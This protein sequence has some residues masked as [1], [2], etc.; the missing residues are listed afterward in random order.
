MS[1]TEKN[2]KKQK[3]RNNEYYNLQQTFDDLYEQSRKDK[4]FRGLMQII[5]QKENILLAYR[6]IKKNKGSRTQGVDA[7]DIE[8]LANMTAEDLVSFIRKKLQNYFPKKVKRVEIPK[9]NGKTRPLGIPTIEDRLIQQCILQV[10]EPIC[11]A[12]FYKH[13]YGFRPLRSAKHAITRCCFQIN[14]VKLHYVVDVDIKGFFDN[15]DH[16]KL[17]KQLWAL[18]IRDKSLLKVISKMLKAE[19]DGV[20]IPTKGTPQGGIL[21]PLLANVALNE[22]DWWIASQWA[23]YKSHYQYTVDKRDGCNGHM[24]EALKKRNLKEMYIVRYADDFKIFCRNYADAK[25]TFIAVKDWLETRLKLEVSPEKSKIT[26]LKKNYSEF[27]GIK[28]KAVKKKKI[29]IKSQLVDRY[30]SRSYIADKAKTRILRESKELI[31][32][33]QRATGKEIFAIIDRYNAYVIGVHNYYNMASCCSKDFSEIAFLSH[34]L[35]ENRLDLRRKKYGEK[36]PRYILNKYG[37]SQ[38]LRFVHNKPFLPIS[39]V[40]FQMQPAFNGLSPYVKTDRQV[41]H[42]NQ[43]AVSQEDIKYLLKHPSPDKSVEYNDNRI[44]L[45]VAQYGKCAVTGNKL[46]VTDMNCHH[47]KP[48]I[49][50]GGDEYKNLIIVEGDIH[51][52][53]HA[54]SLDTIS[55]YFE[56][57]NLD[58][59]MIEK[60]NS[61]K[62]QAQQ[63]PIL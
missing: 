50:G 57:L 59:K 16:A 18:G 1:K 21:S 2:L 5:T 62:K 46:D 8:Y 7:K 26:N 56:N 43:K 55:S 60:I 42:S 22:L 20:G 30:L 45:F 34:S 40:R 35:R 51:R 25:K 31:K 33:I 3:L 11:E 44:A 41:I 38:R 63:D 17:I 28:L 61:L 15:I 6:N 49:H 9:P 39:Y 36:L 47:K 27:L 32:K 53:I 54:E 13:S 48:L 19:I 58:K 52:L 24:Y 14:V 23:E 4:Y 37:K 10:M 29:V 12:K